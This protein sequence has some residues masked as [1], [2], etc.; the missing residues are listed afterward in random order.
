LSL[1]S[2]DRRFGLL[3]ATNEVKGAGRADNTLR[4]TVQEKT[5]E[6]T[7]KLEGR[8]A[9]PWVDELRRTWLSLAP[10]LGSKHLCVDLCEVTFVDAAGKHLLT[11]I[12]KS[13]AGFRADT[14]L[15]KFLVEEIERGQGTQ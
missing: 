13:G 1:H 10:S 12:R 7:I 3:R 15:T 5:K 4:I 6:A 14:P 11:D 8:I 9:G 2:P